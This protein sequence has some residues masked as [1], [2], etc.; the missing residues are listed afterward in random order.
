[1]DKKKQVG[2]RMHPYM[3]T[4]VEAANYTSGHAS[5]VLFAHTRV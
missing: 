5:E 3:Q 1:M 4:M 2:V